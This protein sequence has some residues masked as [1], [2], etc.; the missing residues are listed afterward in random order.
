ME[1]VRTL[2]KKV[3]TYIR[4]GLAV[5]LYFRGKFFE[6]SSHKDHGGAKITK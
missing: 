3:L 4:C 2:K 5:L 6:E 1:D